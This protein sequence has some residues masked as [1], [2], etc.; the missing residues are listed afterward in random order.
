MSIVSWNVRGLGNPCAF[1]ALR[2]LIKQHSP[3][4]LFLMETRLT[5][6]KITTIKNSLGFAGGFEVPRRGLGGGLML[7]WSADVDVSILSFSLSH[8]DCF[9]KISTDFFRFSGFY[10]SPETCNRSLSWSLLR[11][12]KNVSCGPWLCMGD[13]NELL[14]PSDKK[15]GALRPEFCMDSFRSY[16]EDCNISPLVFNGPRFT[17]DNKHSDHSR[18]IER[19]DWALANDEWKNQFSA[20]SLQHRGFYRSDHRAIQVLLAPTK[21][22]PTIGSNRRSRF[23]YE[24]I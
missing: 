14:Y 5:A 8:I 17:F 15:G 13:F 21:H 4:I 12:L 7:F 9:V 18:T 2:M 11:R 24:A 22:S 6:D 10:G 23:R 3:K 1:R 16:I 19:L 20:A